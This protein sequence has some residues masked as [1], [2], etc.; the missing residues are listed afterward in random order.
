MRWV[1][2]QKFAKVALVGLCLVMSS[3]AAQISNAMASWVG[4]HQS[5]LIASWGPPQHVSIDGKSGA[6][7]IYSSYVDIGQTPG[8]TFRIGRT[9]F[10]TAPEQ[11]G[12]QRSRRHCQVN[13]HSCRTGVLSGTL[14]SFRSHFITPG[15]TSELQN[16]IKYPQSGRD[17]IAHQ[18][19]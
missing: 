8:Q 17:F 10:Y 5:E 7:L 13:G 16:W 11:Q 2:S 6:V 12:Y 15:G 1:I 9:T 18:L 14:R 3:C 19:T 4:H